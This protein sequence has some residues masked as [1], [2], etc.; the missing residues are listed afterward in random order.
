MG[1]PDFAVPTLDALE[2]SGRFTPSLVVSQPDRPRGR[3]QETSPTPVRARA[4]EFGIATQVMSKKTYSDVVAE[5]RDHKPDVIVVVAF[6]IIV[7]RDLLDMPLHGCVNV[8]ASLLPSH[9]GVSP[10][11]AAILAGDVHTG[12]STMLMDEGIDT[13]NMLL[14][15]ETKII[16]SESAGLLS[17]RL[18]RLGAHLL[19]RTL[20]GV[21]DG[22]IVG[23]AQPETTTP[24]TRKIK[25]E[26]GHLDWTEPAEALSRRIRAMTPWPSAFTFL[27][28]KRLIIQEATVIR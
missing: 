27:D 17:D 13:G 20:D 24:Y 23:Q 22:S 11:Q 6:G 26:H 4:L 10:I 2:G 28:G 8:H 25:K 9:R 12:C 19:I 21:F 5:I 16:E 3:G 7:K 1:S 15:E 14:S 18:A